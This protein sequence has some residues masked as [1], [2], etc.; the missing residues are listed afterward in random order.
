[1]MYRRIMTVP[2]FAKAT[3]RYSFPMPMS[4]VGRPLN[5][6]HRSYTGTTFCHDVDSTKSVNVVT[7][8]DLDW[9]IAKPI[10]MTEVE[11]ATTLSKWLVEAGNVTS[12]MR[13]DFLSVRLYYSSL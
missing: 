1:M 3:T 7:A 10:V 2:K 4:S 11:G 13:D 9:G 12:L 8:T 6:C 5:V